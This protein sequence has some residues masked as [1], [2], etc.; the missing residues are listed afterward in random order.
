MDGVVRTCSFLPG[1]THPCPVMPQPVGGQA[2][3]CVNHWTPASLGWL[4]RADLGQ[5]GQPALIWAFLLGFMEVRLST[6]PEF[7]GKSTERR[8][9]HPKMNR[10]SRARVLC[11]SQQSLGLRPGTGDTHSTLVVFPFLF[12]DDLKCISVSCRQSSALDAPVS[13]SL[14]PATFGT[15]SQ[16]VRRPESTTGYDCFLL[17]KPATLPGNLTATSWGVKNK[18]FPSLRKQGPQDIGSQYS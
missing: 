17:E 16:L 1:P 4:H 2:L 14:L 12:Q 6:S 10:Q 7:Y 3:L 18:V 13:C 15:C 11:S 8:A 9:R 5:L